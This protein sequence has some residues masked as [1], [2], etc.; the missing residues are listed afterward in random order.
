MKTSVDAVQK[1]LAAYRITPI[2]LDALRSFGVK[3]TG[4]DDPYFNLCDVNVTDEGD[5]ATKYEICYIT[6]AYEKHGRAT[7]KDPWSL[8]QMAVYHQYDSDT[9]RSTW[10]LVQPFKRSKEAFL[11]QF[12]A[13]KTPHALHKLLMGLSLSDWRWYLNDKRKLIN[14]YNEKALFSSSTYKPVDYDTGFADCQRLHKL[15]ADLSLAQEILKSQEQIASV[16]HSYSTEQKKQISNCIRHIQGFS[17][18]A[19]A[20]AKHAE[21][22]SLLVCYSLEPSSLTVD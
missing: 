6:R 21:G 4:R 20:L 12:T 5:N 8:R 11:K 10:I 17:R 2:F 13:S 7:L 1:I 22:T 9:Q 14:Q 18:T 3:V 16:L 19:T 15:A